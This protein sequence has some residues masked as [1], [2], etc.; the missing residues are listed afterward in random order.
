VESFY[1]YP[2]QDRALMELFR[3]MA[4]RGKLFILINLYKDNPYS[5]QWV[6]K[7]KVPVHVLSAAEYVEMLQKHAFEKVEARR[8][9]DDT[10]TPD[11]YKTKSFN[12]L[13]DLRAFKR[14]GALLLM[15]SKPDLRTPAPG[16]TIY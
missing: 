11:D 6:D 12:S 5:L 14:E 16:Y 9:P 8:I 7:L 4:P 13:E 15:A 3:V 2:D 1:Y 10:P